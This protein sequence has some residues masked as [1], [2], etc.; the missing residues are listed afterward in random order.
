LGHTFKSLLLSG[1]RRKEAIAGALPLTQLVSRFA[2]DIPQDR[3][4]AS[5]TTEI[6]VFRSVADDALINRMESNSNELATITSH[7]RGE[8][9]AKSGVLW[10]CPSCRTATVPGRKKKRDPDNPDGPRYEPKT[11]PGCGLVLTEDQAE[12][13][14]LVMPT[15]QSD[16][17][18]L[19][20][21]YI[22]G[23]DIARR[24]APSR[25]SKELRLDFKGFSFKPAANYTAPKV[26]IRQAG[27][28]LLAVFDDTGARV[29]QS[30][31]WYRLTPQAADQG[32]ALEFLLGVLLSRTM[33]YYIFK[34]FSEVDP[35]R[36]HAKVTHERLKN[37]PVPRVD[38]ANRHQRKLHDEVTVVVK[39]LLRGEAQVG[40][41]EDMRIDVALRELW[42]LT[43]ED[44]L[45]IVLELAELPE[46]QV[47]RDLF[48]HG[49]PRQILRT[50]TD[51][52]GD[53]LAV[54]TPG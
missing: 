42:G 33:A 25:P 31:Y 44:G 26:L 18:A 4:V 19:L 30:V 48:P 43:P 28:G 1:S 36:A 13:N 20:A 6:E 37:L 46:G 41:P 39:E 14:Y 32:Y 45:Y 47:I 29:P 49:I 51:A 5:P 22:D 53:S 3:C 52:P 21:P 9:M 27:V 17:G 50:T 16:A 11:C 54:A 23:D 8:E 40:G 15:G 12:L 2:R 38:F 7:G 24:Y 10:I 34:R 35:A